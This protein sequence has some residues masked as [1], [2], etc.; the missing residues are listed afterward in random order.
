LDRTSFDYSRKLISAEAPIVS[1]VVRLIEQALPVDS[2]SVFQLRWPV[3]T[4]MILNTLALI[5][6]RVEADNTLEARRW[7]EETV[8]MAAEAL[9]VPPVKPY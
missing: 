3:V 5:D 8:A 4:R 6:E 7:F 2:Q 9:I 1:S